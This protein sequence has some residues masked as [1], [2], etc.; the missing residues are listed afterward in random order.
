[1]ASRDSMGQIHWDWLFLMLWP[2]IN[3]VI[4]LI[5]QVLTSKEL[6]QHVFGWMRPGSNCCRR[7]NSGNEGGAEQIEMNVLDKNGA[8]V[9]FVT[10]HVNCTQTMNYNM[11][12]VLVSKN[13][14]W[15]KMYLISVMWSMCILLY[16]NMF[17]WINIV[18]L[19]SQWSACYY[20]ILDMLLGG[21]PIAPPTYQVIN[22]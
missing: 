18:F 10:C 12:V 19:T 21:G 22:D 7:D 14:P 17:W 5:I 4:F 2:S 15:P 11:L 1:M 8:Q 3:Y 9:W 16:M 20:S 13:V 6:R